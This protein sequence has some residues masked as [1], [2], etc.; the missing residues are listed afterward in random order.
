[1]RVVPTL[2]IAFA[3]AAGAAGCDSGDSGDA[4][5]AAY[6]VGSWEL[7]AVHDD[8]G[9]RT[10]QVQVVLDALTIDFTSGG[11]FSMLVDYSALVNAGGTPD[12][13][14]VGGYGVSA[15][16]SLVVTPGAA[17]VPF[18]V[19]THGSARA[20]LSAPAVIVNELLSGSDLDLG[21]VGTAV[22]AIE[23]P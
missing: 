7:V 6:F 17:S 8:T 2:I 12:T 19:V 18:G 21:L 14:F 16:G 3:A 9:D 23:R 15:G 5:T 22:L 11:Q 4:L 10:A 1:M 13:T 20:D